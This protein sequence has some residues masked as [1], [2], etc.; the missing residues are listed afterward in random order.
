VRP[1][2][3][4]ER[5][6]SVGAR[7]EDADRSRAGLRERRRDRR[8]DTARADDQRAA[9]STT[10]PFAAQASNEPFAVEQVA[11]ESAVGIAAD[12]IAR[13]R[14]L[15]RRRSHVE[16]GHGAHLVRHRDER[17]ADVLEREHRAQE[18]RVVL[19]PAAH[20][21][22]HRIDSGRSKYGL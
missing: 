17:A 19:V 1:Q 6:G 2:P 22:D 12:R 9:P 18:G 21:H 16:Q 3:R 4:G 15:H 7:V 13:A 8:A 14:D 10:Q 11:D 20:R 5:F